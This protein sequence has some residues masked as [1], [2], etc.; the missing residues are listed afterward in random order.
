MNEWI[1]CADRL[2]KLRQQVVLA[3]ARRFRSNDHFGCSKDVGHREDAGTRPEQSYWSTQ[4]EMRAQ[5]LD[6]FTHW[7]P[8]SEPSLHHSAGPKP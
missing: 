1:A 5:T 2:P 3:N 4:G 7:M 6:A 8:L